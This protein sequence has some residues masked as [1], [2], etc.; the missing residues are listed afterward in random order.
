M[1]GGPRDETQG[2]D[3]RQDT[4]LDGQ[5]EGLIDEDQR[6]RLDAD[7]RDAAADDRDAVAAKRDSRADARDI[8]AQGRDAALS[9]QP[10]RTGAR[11]FAG[12]DRRASAEDR[13]EAGN[14]RLRSRVDRRASGWDRA[15]AAKAKARLLQ[16][17]DDADKLP[18]V[19]LLIGQAQG[20]LMATFG[21]NA[22]EALVEIGDRADRDRVG[23][24]EAARRTIAEG[25]LSVIQ[26]R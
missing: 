17:L 10:D 3:T 19:T 24:Q 11:R 1:T 16:A 15:V 6:L 14:D 9:D 13:R 22:A 2:I 4:A 25:A 7:D 20:L 23:L 26:G 12:Q 5:H 18:E 8:H 21:G